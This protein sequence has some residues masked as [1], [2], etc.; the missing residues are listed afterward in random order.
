MATQ[1]N[2]KNQDTSRNNGGDQSK[3]EKRASQKDDEYRFASNLPDDDKGSVP[4]SEYQDYA[5]MSREDTSEAPDVLLDI[6]VVKVDEINFELEDLRAHVSL[7]AEVLDLLQLTAGPTLYLGR[8]ALEIKG[9]EAQALL[10]VRLDNVAAIVDR[11]LTTIDRNP[12]ILENITKSLGNTVEEVGQGAGKA[13]GE[14]GE[15]AGSAVEDVGEGAGS[16]V[17]D[18]GEGAGSAVE[19][20]GEGAGSAVEDVGEG[21]GSAVEDVGEG[22]GEAVEDVGEGAGEAVESTGEAVEDVGEGAGEAVE[23]TGEA[24][25]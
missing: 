20:V 8:V 3:S 15:G 23:S 5:I 6:P 9:V 4:E 19:D 7:Q 1:K 10:K 25:E 16:A 24:V 18:V 12:Q 21:A 17:E 2:K 14:I 13:V 22:A 11:V